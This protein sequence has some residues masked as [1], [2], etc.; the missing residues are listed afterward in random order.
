MIDLPKS[1]PSTADSP[2]SRSATAV[3]AHRLAARL[4]VRVG[5]VV[6][7]EIKGAS[8]LSQAEREYLVNQASA[9]I[10]LNPSRTNKAEL[11]KAA[12]AQAS[13]TQLLSVEINGK[14]A[15]LLSDLALGKGQ[16]VS[17]RVRLDGQLQ[18]LTG[19]L[20][21]TGRMTGEGDLALV[22]KAGVTG[23]SPAQLQR[24]LASSPLAP[25]LTT[26]QRADQLANPTLAAIAKLSQRY[27]VQS[28]AGPNTVAS[29]EAAINK[30][31]P[32]QQQQVRD[33]RQ[34]ISQVE[35]KAQPLAKLVEALQALP[36]RVPRAWLKLAPEYLLLA[37]RL[38][39]L[40]HAAVDLTR[41]GD[42]PEKTLNEALSRSGTLLE[43][44]LR[45]GQFSERPET[46]AQDTKRNL[47]LAL[48]SVEKLLNTQARGLEP[49][50]KAGLEPLLKLLLSFAKPSSAPRAAALE[51]S[52][53]ALQ[54]Q[55]RGALAQIQVQQYRSTLPL[56]GD[57]QFATPSLLLDIPVRWFDGFGSVAM[58]W[59]EYRAP[60]EED[61]KKRKRKQPKHYWRVYMELV[62]EQSETLGID[63]GICEK[64]MDAKMWASSK[65][66]QQRANSGL[67]QLTEQLQARGLTVKEIHCEQ[68]DQ[69]HRPMG[70][71]L[72]MINE[73]T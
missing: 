10:E 69:P 32:L 27:G 50:A 52:L 26:T 37:K 7:A 22:Q 25:L 14:T 67:H 31:S 61:N 9:R 46:L 6:P 42:N 17:V 45:D 13:R 35:G 11:L 20:A 68:T 51:A 3:E 5:Q 73:R 12:L 40:K 49:G 57:P 71:E 47:L 33:L 43:R 36:E 30:L 29:L 55:L 62:L 70:M 23:H 19:G 18:L 8:A 1:S 48:E 4:G 39:P 66:L 72:M 2:A 38:H 16:I 41:L 60:D 64:Q 63:L 58:V 15:A 28:P 56:V 24:A 34:A 65:N 54:T 59:Q 21:P 53:R 44:H